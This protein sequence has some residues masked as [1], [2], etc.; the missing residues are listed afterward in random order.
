[1]GYFYCKLCDVWWG[2]WTIESIAEHNFKH[3]QK[4][5]ELYEATAEEDKA[6]AEAG[7]ADWAERLDKEDNEQE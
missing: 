1:M 2:S 3:E 5:K 6:F 7:L 4:I